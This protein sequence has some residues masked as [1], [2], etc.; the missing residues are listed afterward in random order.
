MKSIIAFCFLLSFALFLPTQAQTWSD[1]FETYTTGSFPSTWTPD[2]N[3]TDIGT[4]YV[5]TTTF[6]GGAKSLRLH[7]QLAGCWGAL[8]YRPLTLSAPFEVEVAIRNGSESLSGCHPDR[9]GIGLRQGTSWQNPAREFILFKGNGNVTSAAGNVLQSYST[10]T[11]YTV[12][13]RYERPTSSQV[14]ISYWINGVYKGVETLTAHAQE[15]Q[16]TNFEINAQEGTVWF[17]DISI[18]R[19][20]IVTSVE[21]LAAN[22]PLSYELFQ[23]YPNPFNPSTKI[24][25]AVQERA[26]VQLVVF[27]ILGQVVSTLVDAEMTPGIY[28][29][30][31]DAHSY[32]S[33][34]YFYRLIANT[35]VQSRR[36]LL[37]K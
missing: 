10:L 35:F 36:M 31:F 14:R 8:A 34:V 7:G 4:N 30:S 13:I 28:E 2:G 33:G 21:Q 26:N 15:D 19:G 25:F 16:M 22:L 24:T 18:G 9:G 23:N 6:L 27:N 12:R 29:A 37:L 20:S 32:A 11:W 1:G 3:A 17:D 5:T